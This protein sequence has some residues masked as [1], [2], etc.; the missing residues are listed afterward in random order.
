MGKKI[1]KNGEKRLLRYS[2]LSDVKSGY[3]AVTLSPNYYNRLTNDI[4]I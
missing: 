2:F 4:K 3:L 1:F